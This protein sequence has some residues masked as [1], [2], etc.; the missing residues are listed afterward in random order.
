MGCAVSVAAV[1]DLLPD[2]AVP[3]SL[4]RFATPDSGAVDALAVHDRVR[5][6]ESMPSIPTLLAEWHEH[7]SQLFALAADDSGHWY[8][9]ADVRPL[10]PVQPGQ[11]L[12][13][14]ANYRKHVV[15]IVVSELDDDSQGRTPEQKR[16]YAEQLMDARAAQGAPYVFLGAS[17]ALSGATDDIVLD[18]RPGSMHDWELELAVVI[19][20]GGRAISRTEAMAHVG[21]YT[22]ANDITSRDLVYRKDLPKLGTDWL[23]AKNSPTFLPTG[24][25]VV[26]AEFV[27]DPHALRIT[28]RHNGVVRQDETTDDMIFDIPRLI[29]YTSSIV[30]LS[31]GDLLLTGSPAGNGAHWGVSLHPGDVL[32]CTISGLG[33]QA[34]TC[35]AR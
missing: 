7:R 25:V 6:L 29:E 27:A 31:P 32:D 14:G 17:S 4:G 11:V 2:A 3:F 20:R 35:V 18:D 10:C 24:P 21:G 30:T 8:D 22:I 1:T 23:A 15:D 16:A 26:P 28:L 5:V 19:G 9:A 33:R 12:Q 13:A 34:T